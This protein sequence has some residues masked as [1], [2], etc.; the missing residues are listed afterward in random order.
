[1]PTELVLLIGLQG[2]G[3]SSFCSAHLADTHTL[4]SKDRLRN[5]RNRERRQRQ[6]I[7]EALGAGRRSGGR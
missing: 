7:E 1:M 5:N 2:S 4:V 6:L 3:K